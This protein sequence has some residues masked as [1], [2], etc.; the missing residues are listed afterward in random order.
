[1]GHAEWARQ[2][3][4]PGPIKMDRLRE[5][6]GCVLDSN[7]LAESERRV[8]DLE[9]ALAKSERPRHS[10]AREL[11]SLRAFSPPAPPTA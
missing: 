7:A 2:R 11:E 9:K 8:E 5:L 1:M 10:I 3:I 6:S 4:V